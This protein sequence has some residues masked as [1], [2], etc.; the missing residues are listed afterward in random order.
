MLTREVDARWERGLFI[1]GV[2]R[3]A[4]MGGRCQ[5]WRGFEHERAATVCCVT[6]NLRGL[7]T[8]QPYWVQVIRQRSCLAAFAYFGLRGLCRRKRGSN[9]VVLKIHGIHA[10]FG[11]LHVSQPCNRV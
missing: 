6:R 11:Y 10:S 4:G 8:V 1:A 3:G 9:L 2:L 5:D 7:T